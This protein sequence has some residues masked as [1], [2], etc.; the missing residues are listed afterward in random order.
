[1]NIVPFVALSALACVA[2]APG[3]ERTPY[4]RADSTMEVSV[5]AAESD[6]L[7]LHIVVP[8]RI[9]SGEQ[10][11]VTF[12]VENVSGRP[13]ELYL[14]GRTIAFNVIIMR[15]GEVVWRRLDDDAIPAILRLE[16]LERGGILELTDSWDQRSAKGERVPPGEYTVRVELL[17]DREPIVSPVV[18]FRIGAV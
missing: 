17:T 8:E 10:M 16:M 3:Q 15:D 6:S 5:P 12:R 4:M 11:Q 2:C 7:R 9:A 18:G 13:L 1:M 14:R